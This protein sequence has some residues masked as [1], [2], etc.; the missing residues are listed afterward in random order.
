M[1]T[2]EKHYNFVSKIST[3]FLKQ[4]DFNKA[5]NKSLKFL[6]KKTNADRAYI[7]LLRNN[8]KFMD[9]THEYCKK[10]ISREIESLQNIKTKDVKWWISELKKNGNIHIEDVT[11]LP[12]TAKVER[13]SLEEQNIKSVICLPFYFNKEMIGFVGLDN[14]LEASTW[15]NENIEYLNIATN[16]ISKAIEKEN[17][18]I[19]MSQMNSTLQATLEST[20]D[21]IVVI[22]KDGTILNNNKIF[23][24]MWN[25]KQVLK[26][27]SSSLAL[28]GAKELLI[29]PTPSE[30]E[31]RIKNILA[32][33]END[34]SF[35]AYLK[36]ERIIKLESHPMHINSK[37]VGRVWRC[38]DITKQRGYEQKLHLI[39]KVF[40]KSNDAILITDASAKIIE[41][42]DSFEQIT[43]YKLEEIYGKNPSLLQSNWHDKPFYKKLWKEIEKLGYWEGEIWDRRKNGEVYVSRTL[44][45]KVENNAKITNYIAIAK[46]ITRKKEYEDR[47]KQLAFYDAL[48]L[49]PNRAYFE[50]NLN[51]VLDESKRYK[52]K[53][54]VLFLDLD[55][56]KYV[57]DTFGHLIG[58][59]LL[60]VVAKRLAECV[61][62]SDIVSRIGGDEFTVIVKDIR[63]DIDLIR[64]SKKIINHLL[65]PVEIE[66]QELYIGTSIGICMYPEDAKSA[67]ELTKKADI[68]MYN[69]KNNGKNMYSFFCDE[70]NKSVLERYQKEQYM[71]ESIIKGDFILQYQPFM[72]CN[73]NKINAVEALIRWEHPK[74]GLVMPSDFIHIAEENG[75]IIKLGEWVFEKVC[76]DFK[77]FSKYSIEKVSINISV[78]QLMDVKFVD[79][80]NE[81]I[82]KYE[83]DASML[84]FEITEDLFLNKSNIVKTNLENLQKIGISFALDDFGT[85]YSSLSYIK[86]FDIDTIK[87]DR[88]FVNSMMKS[89]NDMAIVNTILFLSKQLGT[90]VVAEGVETSEQLDFFKSQDKCNIQG[91][92]LSKPVDIKSLKDVVSNHSI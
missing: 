55:N 20:D 47:I 50:Q 18:N 75:L 72:C 64:I 66:N 2:K 29:T 9:N 48:T 49:L 33:G 80:V 70:M 45:T 81:S 58:D 19:H 12:K 4:Y 44:I 90:D 41:V 23:S 27:K 51:S 36:D 8:G 24:N 16:I 67:D 69:S 60:Q 13:Q 65:E 79:F 14:V 31:K 1:K 89:D 85:G 35:I 88:S 83:I 84:E 5:I 22:K 6:A 78:K 43:G 74:L 68:A 63:E 37:H 32:D 73:S 76:K 21:G 15:D 39:S 62:D 54:G 53:F 38:I 71:R 82:S 46:D 91:Y 11:K 30:F 77:E 3:I 87:I 42:N 52:R 28:S 26:S 86:Q 57:N 25:I 61:R 7:F 34:D 56:F 17:S 92:L 40:E 59:K 10:G